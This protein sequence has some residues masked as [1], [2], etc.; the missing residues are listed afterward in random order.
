MRCGRARSRPGGAVGLA[1]VAALLA[2]CATIPDSS[3]PRVVEHLDPSRGPTQQSVLQDTRPGVGATESQIV[4]GFIRAQPAWQD[5]HEPARRFLTAQAAGQWHDDAEM[6]VASGPPKVGALDAD[7]VIPV[8]FTPVGRV[9]PDGSYVPA[10]GPAA[11]PVT[12]P[13]R[14]RRED[15][16]WRIAVFHNTLVAQPP[17]R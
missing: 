13:L 2:G 10:F 7:H 4:D 1:V 14:L 12:W 3:P 8:T 11:A 16:E 17:A 15:G 6:I 5:G 9:N